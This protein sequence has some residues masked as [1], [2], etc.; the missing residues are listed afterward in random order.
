MRLME[1]DAEVVAWL[2]TQLGDYPF[3]LTG[4][5][6]TS[7]SPG[8]A[9]ENQ[10]RPTYPVLGVQRHGHRSCTSWRTSGSATRSR[11]R[12]GATSGSTRAPPPSWRCA[13]TRRT[14]ARTPSGWLESTWSSF[15]ADDRSGSWSS[16]TP[17]RS[18]IFDWPV[19]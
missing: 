8:F 4:G 3:S 2:A 1:Q 16:P 5:L 10:T 14:A 13:T 11:S 19:Y 17:G 7:L 6:T 12:A 15:G 18:S 9:L